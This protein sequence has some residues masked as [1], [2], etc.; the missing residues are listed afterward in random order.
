MNTDLELRY[1][2]LPLIGHPCHRLQIITEREF[3]LYNVLCFT[4][5]IGQPHYP[6]MTAKF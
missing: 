6:T 3:L 1:S 2:L 5:T 4:S